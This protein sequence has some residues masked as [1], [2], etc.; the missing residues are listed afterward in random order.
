[1]NKKLLYFILLTSIILVLFFGLGNDILYA[2]TGIKRWIPFVV[3]IF[4]IPFLILK[5]LDQYNIAGKAKIALS[6][7]PILIIGPL[8]GIW[9]GY[10]SKNDLTENGIKTYGII[11]QKWSSKPRKRSGEWLVK[12]KF[13]VDGKVFK[14][15]SKEDEKNIYKVGDTLTILYSS[16]NPENNTIIELE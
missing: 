2:K 9:T 14:T 5:V 11:S 3:I 16:E 12:C 15:F 10:L 13:R 8:F 4:V 7:G 6:V 1:M